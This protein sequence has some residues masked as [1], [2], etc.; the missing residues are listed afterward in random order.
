MAC[1]P[2]QPASCVV[3]VAASGAEAATAAVANSFAETIREGAVW[4][5][6]TTVAWWV[7]VPAIDLDA[8][9]ATAIRGYVLGL[10]AL[11]AVAGVI[12]QGVLLA[13][14]RRPEPVL[15]VGRGL[16]TLALWTSI[17]VVGPAAA[18]RA[19]DA[20]S[21]W[22]LTQAAGGRAADRIVDLARLAPVSAPGA[23]MLLGLLMMLAGLVQALLM[24]FREASVVILAG[25]VVLAAAGSMLGATR[26]WLPRVLGWLLALICYK[27]AAALVYASALTLVG[28]S[29]DAR[30]FF[31]GIAMI[32]LSIIALPALMRLFTW[33]TG[34]VGGGGGGLAAL[35]GATAASLHAGAALSYHRT[36]AAQ[37]H[38][39]DLRNDLGPDGG[40]PALPPP[41]TGP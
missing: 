5:I 38:S 17:G 34:S 24:L 25:V 29:Q 4:V 19:G 22:V 21:D 12:W 3:S 16:F 6:R 30:S 40:P 39:Q 33:T 20:F 7:E 1:D 8:S 18:L 26:P 28:D 10:A 35:A 37:D 32:L 36:R 23:V 9:P 41:P 31:V 14:S 13:L 11:V 27:P 15:A 2:L